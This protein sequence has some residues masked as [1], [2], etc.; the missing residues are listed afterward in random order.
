MNFDGFLKPPA[1]EATV[2]LID[3]AL[4]GMIIYYGTV[5]ERFLSQVVRQQ[6]ATL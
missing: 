5:G 3:W 2:V 6:T 1:I 4:S